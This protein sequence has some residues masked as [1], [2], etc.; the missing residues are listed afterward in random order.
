MNKPVDRFR[1]KSVPVRKREP[2]PLVIDHTEGSRSKPS[3]SKLLGHVKTQKLK[4]MKKIN[5]KEPQSIVLTRGCLKL[6]LNFP[7]DSM[8]KFRD[9]NQESFLMRGFCYCKNAPI[10]VF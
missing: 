5:V 2:L 4:D 10:Q 7:S 8:V 9:K 6:S 1:S 3:S